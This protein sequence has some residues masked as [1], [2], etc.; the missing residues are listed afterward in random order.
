MIVI[1]IVIEKTE[2]LMSLVAVLA[3]DQNQSDYKHRG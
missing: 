2:R 1:L 3:T